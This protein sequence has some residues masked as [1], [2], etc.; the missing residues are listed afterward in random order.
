MVVSLMRP[1]DE[2]IGEWSCHW[3]GHL[4][5]RINPNRHMNLYK[6]VMSKHPATPVGAR[7]PQRVIV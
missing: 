3:C 7:H 6:H 4:Y 2:R 5:S 1:I